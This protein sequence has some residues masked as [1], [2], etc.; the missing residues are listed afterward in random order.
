[1]DVPYY[2]LDYNN[3]YYSNDNSSS[4]YTETIAT[5]ETPTSVA[6]EQL[7]STYEIC[8]PAGAGADFS[9]AFIGSLDESFPVEPQIIVKS[10]VLKTSSSCQY[11]TPIDG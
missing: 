10:V 2:E 4:V 7:N 1:M 5:T 6:P 11:L 8:L 9:V 3:T